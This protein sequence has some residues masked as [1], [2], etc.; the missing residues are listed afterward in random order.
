MALF[1]IT[2]IINFILLFAELVF[3]ALNVPVEKNMI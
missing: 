1:E 2:S 3:K